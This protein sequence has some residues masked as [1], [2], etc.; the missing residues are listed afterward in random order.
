M[1]SDDVRKRI[2]FQG[3]R[4]DGIFFPSRLFPLE[5]ASLKSGLSFSIIRGMEMIRINPTTKI[6][7]FSYYSYFSL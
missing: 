3:E 4:C 2:S 7:K 5:L 1:D 6:E